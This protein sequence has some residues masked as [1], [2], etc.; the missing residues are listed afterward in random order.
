MLLDTCEDERFRGFEIWETA[1]Q[2]GARFLSWR[3]FVQIYP[4]AQ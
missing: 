2:E 1:R 3:G 4:D